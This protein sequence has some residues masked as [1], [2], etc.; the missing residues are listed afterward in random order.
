MSLWCKIIGH[1]REPQEE[2]S[3]VVIKDLRMVNLIEVC[4]RCGDR[5]ASGVI[6][7]APAG[8]RGRI[9]ARLA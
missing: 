4:K 8:R 7:I 3:G 9:V 5:K 6:G 2:D 1:K